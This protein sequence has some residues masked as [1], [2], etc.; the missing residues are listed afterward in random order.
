MNNKTISIESYTF[1][2]SDELLVDAN[3]W[4]S[5]YGPQAKPNT[6]RT[7]LYSNAI[8]RI[9]MAKG[10]IFVDVLIISEFINRY[11]RFEFK[12]KRP[13]AN[14]NEFKNFRISPDFKLVAEAIADDVRRI[15]KQSRRLGSGFESLDIDAFLKNYE[16][17]CADFND[18]VLAEI[19]RAH[20]L[21]LITHDADFK[22]WGITILTANPSLLG[23]APQ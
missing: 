14:P 4:L 5:V 7:K 9:I 13:N 23:S 6:W 18:M 12:L 1:S 17:E 21:K 15:L 10:T 20:E 19:C 3:I 11:S 22:T 2:E 16:K 8:K